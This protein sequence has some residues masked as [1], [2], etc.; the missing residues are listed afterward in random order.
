VE[1]LFEALRRHRLTV[2][3]A[4]GIAP[5]MVASDRTLRDV[6]AMRPRTLDDLLLAHGIGPHKAERYGPGLLDVVNAPSPLPSSPRGRG[7][8]HG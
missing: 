5:F 7:G 4:E 8:Q 3:R 1:A 6:A 2:A